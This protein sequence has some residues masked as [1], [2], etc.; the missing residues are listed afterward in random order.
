MNK[1]IREIR[2]NEDSA[3]DYEDT[4][5]RLIESSKVDLDGYKPYIEAGGVI[6]W[7]NADANYTVYATPFYDCADYIPVFIADE[8]DSDGPTYKIYL[9]CTG[10][11]MRDSVAYLAAMKV[12]WRMIT[13]IATQCWKRG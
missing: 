5:L 8:G 9:K 11:A 3:F 13:C 12:N 10:D 2:R 4:L 7:E 6:A 1:L